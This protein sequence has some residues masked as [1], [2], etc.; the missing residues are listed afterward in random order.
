MPPPTGGNRAMQQHWGARM[1]DNLSRV[2]ASYDQEP[3]REWR[4]LEGGAQARLEYVVTCHALER[5]LPPPTPPCHLL[6]AG[7]GPGRYTLA[8]ARRDYRM[9]LLDLSPALLDLARTRIAEADPAVQQRVVGVVEGS[10]T[11][12]T[13][14]TDAQFDAILGLGGVLSHL[15]DSADRRRALGELRRVLRPGGVLFVSAFNR[16]ARFR[17]AVQW[18][19]SWEQLIPHLMRGGQVP[20]GPHGIPTYVFDPDE[21]VDELARAGLAIRALYGC[22]GLGAHLQEEHL[23]ALMEDVDRWPI[24]RQ[25]LLETCDHPAII[26]VSSH[27]L[28]VVGHVSAG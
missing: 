5:H 14:F 8:L 28:A 23:L 11:D 6:D 24:W 3:E 13:G 2:R 17:S 10:V 15:P 19:D 26:G 9:T 27:L 16:L 20:M 4:R 22:Q 18:P 21:F 12:L 25:V 7:G 1:A